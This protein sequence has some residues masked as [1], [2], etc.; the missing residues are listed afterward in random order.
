MEEVFISYADENKALSQELE[1]LLKESGLIVHRDKST[2]RYGD[3]WRDKVHAKIRTCGAFILLWSIH[4]SK[5]YAVMEEILEAIKSNRRIIPCLLDSTDLSPLLEG[6]HYLRLHDIQTQFREILNALGL[7]LES[8][9]A[10]VSQDVKYALSTYRAVVRK[11]FGVFQVLFF[12]REKT[13]D[14]AY[15][16]VT[17]NPGLDASKSQRGNV[18]PSKLLDYA[19]IHDSDY[20]IA[21][22]PG[23]GK[24]STLHYLM[25]LWAESEASQLVIYVRLKDYE[26]RFHTDFRDFL[27]EEFY[28]LLHFQTRRVFEQA[29]DIFENYRCLILLDG[30][31]EVPVENYPTLIKKLNV[32]RES[33]R[34]CNL[35]ITTRIDGF[36][37][38][39]EEDF[40]TWRTFTIAR[41]DQSKVEEFISCWFNDEKKEEDLVQ[42][43]RSP[44]LLELAGRAFLLALICLVFEDEGELGQ[45]RTAL[46]EQA[47]QYLEKSRLGKVTAKMLET[48]HKVL[49]GIALRYLQL[50]VNEIR[51]ELLTAIVALEL[52]E[53]TAVTPQDFLDD[54]VNDTGLMQKTGATYVFTHKSFQEYYAALAVENLPNGR[55][56]LLDYARVS[57]WEESIRLYAGGIN[58]RADQEDFISDLWQKNPALALRTATEC[59]QLSP[60]FLGKLVSGSNFDNRLRMIQEVRSSLRRMDSDDAKRFVIETLRPLFQYEMDSA[61]LYMGVQLLQEFDPD[62]TGKIMYDTFYRQA[63]SLLDKLVS[64]PKYKLEFVAIPEG[65]FLMG[66]SSSQDVIE[67]PAHEVFISKFMFSKYQLTNLAYEAIWELRPTEGKR[68]VGVSEEDDQPVVNINWYDAYVCALKV[69]CRLPT[70]A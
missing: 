19:L 37:D 31:D 34:A 7:E 55:D 36:K 46:Y 15:I 57:A 56:L 38:G 60:A 29:D 44:R 68:V 45:N 11:Q 52:P 33:H 17:L 22:H 48:R 5:S 9:P 42:K 59:H 35:I 61:V 50:N 66:D 41:F 1:Y 24:T 6:K 63:P 30:L 65:T 20:V 16:E 54:L 43:L 53:N 27:I 3:E 14:R 47:T 2:L 18:V 10:D 62:D 58:T 26:P 51:I 21:G 70:E 12:G 69:G 32:F 4:A 13:I 64:N 40:S 8:L 67:R 28:K 23:A 39:R 49:Q 25:H